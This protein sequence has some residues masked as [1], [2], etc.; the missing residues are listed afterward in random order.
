LRLQYHLVTFAIN[1]SL[2]L[3][4]SAVKPQV[5]QIWNLEFGIWNLEFGIW[6][7]EFGIWNLEFAV[8]NK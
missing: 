1:T 3:S 2:R 4:A 7:L 8:S 5:T 6:N